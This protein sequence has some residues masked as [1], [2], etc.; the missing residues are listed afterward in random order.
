MRLRSNRDTEEPKPRVAS[1][2][3]GTSSSSRR[4]NRTTRR[5]GVGAGTSTHQHPASSRT[6][7]SSEGGSVGI[8]TAARTKRTAGAS[9]AVGE[10]ETK[11]KKVKPHASEEV[12]STSKT[13]ATRLSP[14]TMSVKEG[15]GLGDPPV[16]K[17][18][19]GHSQT[20]PQ[21]LDGLG[22]GPEAKRAKRRNRYDYLVT[23]NGAKNI[24][25]IPQHILVSVFAM[26]P[27][28]ERI[29]AERV[30]RRWRYLSREFAWRN[31]R[32]FSFS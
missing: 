28:V 12:P 19:R 25:D 29:K 7:G 22:E 20:P 23:N 9:G 32:T 27:I 1:S 16:V 3:S 21:H 18:G 24:G 17:G 8:P 11:R 2:S 4:A 14:E 6:S 13:H 30:C 10:P 15:V 26:L 31:T 5:A